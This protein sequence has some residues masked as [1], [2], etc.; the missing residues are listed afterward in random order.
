MPTPV[1]RTRFTALLAISICCAPAGDAQAQRAVAQKLDSIAGAEV[2]KKEAVGLVAAVVR[3]NDTLLFK[4]YGKANIEDA[5]PMPTDAMFEIGSITKQFTAAAILQL[6]DQGK[7]SLD[8]DITK[9]LPDFD[10]R[11]NRVPLHRLLDHTSGITDITQR[12]EFGILMLGFGL[13]R[14]TMYTLIRRR[15]FQFPTGTAQ[16][17][18]NSAFW[19]LGLVIEKA[20]GMTYERY[21]ETRIF[22]PLGMKH[23]MARCSAEGIPHR[24]RGYILQN[25]R[26]GR[27]EYNEMTWYMGSGMLCSSA[28]DLVTWLKALHGGKVLSPQSYARMITPATLRDGTPVRYGMGVQVSKDVRGLTFIGH[29]GE[30]PGF[31]ARANWYPDAAMAIVVLM[32]NSGDAAPSAM[33]ENLAAEVLP[34]APRQAAE[35][36]GDGAPLA[37]RYEGPGRGGDMV[38]VVTQTPQGIA[39]SINGAPARPLPWIEGLSFSSG[40]AILTF[41]RANG[42]RGLATELRF[43]AGSGYY[44]LKRK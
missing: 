27:A 11:G 4:A 15:P 8:D 44:I 18:N 21:I 40:G 30:I 42:D 12:W 22:E 37:G 16:V 13:P 1:S 34:V 33:A 23:S 36:R 32:N 14:S 7:L 35:F 17:Y 9:W 43:D 39:F 6:H 31:A 20:S 38:V 10:T 5:V 3:G 28:G 26:P 2:L 29:S 24:P 41:R 25:G 19:L